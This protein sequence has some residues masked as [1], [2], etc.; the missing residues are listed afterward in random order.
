MLDIRL[1]GLLDYIYEHTSKND[2]I[3]VVIKTFKDG[4]W[5]E[6][7]S[8]TSG[9]LSN[10]KELLT[11]RDSLKT[12]IDTLHNY[13]LA[14]NILNSTAISYIDFCKIFYPDIP[15][16]PESP[17]ALSGWKDKNKITEWD[18]PI[19]ELDYILD[20]Q[21]EKE[22]TKFVIVHFNNWDFGARILEIPEDKYDVVL[23]L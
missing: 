4:N 21:N 3:K 20:E 13:G 16:C 11:A 12:I 6:A 23:D 2:F 22:D 8:G 1:Q 10:N 15:R 5:E 18:Y 17:L 9:Y 19:T 14:K 7:E